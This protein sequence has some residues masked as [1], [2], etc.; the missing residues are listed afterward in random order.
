MPSLPPLELLAE[1]FAWLPGFDETRCV[2]SR[3][4]HVW[5][6]G[7]TL[8]SGAVFPHATECEHIVKLEAQSLLCYAKLCYA[9]LTML[10]Y[11]RSC[12]EV[13]SGM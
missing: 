7:V 1:S 6:L 3:D 8:H 9:M 11:A 2:S 4:L 10:S 12:E 13:R 5:A